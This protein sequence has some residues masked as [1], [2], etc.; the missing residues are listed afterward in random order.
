MNFKPFYI[1]GIAATLIITGCK[2][3]ETKTKDEK[4]ETESLDAASRYL[5]QLAVSEVVTV[6][7]VT[8]T[9]G[10]DYLRYPYTE[11]EGVGSAVLNYT[12]Y[13][14]D[15]TVSSTKTVEWIYFVDST[16]NK[17]VVRH[18][19]S[20]NDSQ[21]V[22]E[23][24][25]GDFTEQQFV[26]KYLYSFEKEF[27]S[28]LEDAEYSRRRDIFAPDD[29]WY[30]FFYVFEETQEVKTTFYDDVWDLDNVA[31]EF[32]TNNTNDVP[33]SQFLNLFITAQD[34]TTSKPISI[35]ITQTIV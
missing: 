21:T 13:N 2:L 19:V 3:P 9:V 29:P 10:I 23:I 16:T 31:Y 7:I 18:E 5:E 35:K 26:D 33:P 32:V 25:P 12:Y 20:V 8:D 15:K 6:N 28:N 4:Y 17:G 24:I 22:D 30:S 14:Q 1:L 11:E 27:P 34:A